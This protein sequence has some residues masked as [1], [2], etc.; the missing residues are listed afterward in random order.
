MPT[1]KLTPAEHKATAE[2]IDKINV[3]ARKRGF[4]GT[5]ALEL[6]EIVTVRE[7]LATDGRRYSEESLRLL[8]DKA[9]QNGIWIT[10][11]FHQ[12]K[13]TG[14][15]PCYGDWNFVA[16]LDWDQHA[17]LI[18][19][20]APGV[21][22]AVDREGLI[23]GYCAHCKAKRARRKTMLVRHAETGEYRQVG[24][25]CIKDFLGWNAGPVFL[26]E[27]DVAKTVNDG[28]GG[29]RNWE[30]ND[31]VT[32]EVLT[33]AWA[34]TMAYGF[35]RG[36]SWDRTPTRDIV[37]RVMFP[38]FNAQSAAIQRETLEDLAPFMEAAAAKGAQV[39][40]FLL[41]EEFTGNSDYVENMKNLVRPERVSARHIGM[42]A[43]APAAWTKA[44]EAKA[45]REA[46][47]ALPDSVWFGKE[48]ERL[49]YTGTV[50][51]I[52]YVEGDWST[53][54]LYAMTDAKGRRAKWWATGSNP[55]RVTEGD[56]VTLTG[57]IKGH[58]EY[59]GIK[60]TILTRCKIKA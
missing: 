6:A 22:G 54:T 15:A 23:E 34:A 18:V 55:L 57:T 48:K 41:S 50:K 31:L 9:P 13:L 46:A 52:R 40:E 12:V 47:D 8:G 38:A 26:W 28:M 5:F 29:P 42:L 56:V 32:T 33:V 24:S 25:T 36:D 11:V 4:T 20:N 44:K 43:S 37:R 53:K 49:E 1:W 35:A 39:R 14:E 58:E 59:R 30:D 16:V 7:F 2:K 3:R 19:R 27:D 17:G 21:E 45:E 51:V 60:E 10:D